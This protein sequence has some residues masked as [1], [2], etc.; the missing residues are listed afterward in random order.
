[1]PTV[2]VTIRGAEETGG[3]EAAAVVETD[4]VEAA[5]VVE[6]DGATAETKVGGGWVEDGLTMQMI[7]IKG[8]AV[9]KKISGTEK[10]ISGATRKIGGTRRRIH[11]MKWMTD[12]Y[13]FLRQLLKTL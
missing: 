6:T 7:M 2:M 9:G 13:I 3:V 1:M 10:K 12:G 11:G 4:W 5:A 8:V